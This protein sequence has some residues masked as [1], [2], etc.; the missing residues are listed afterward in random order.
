[1]TLQAEI[2]NEANSTTYTKSVYQHDKNVTLIFDGI[3]LP[4]KYEVHFANDKDGSISVACEGS[5]SGVMIPDEL[6]STGSYVYAWVYDTGEESGKAVVYEICI[7]V[8]PKPIPVHTASASSSGKIDY[9][10]DEEDENL[11]SGNYK[12]LLFDK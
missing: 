1:M 10:I 12:V 5:D 9:H 6:L 4:E 8:I 11:V 7:P 3:D 2:Y